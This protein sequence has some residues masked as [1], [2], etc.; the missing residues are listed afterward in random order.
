PGH[1]H[2][3][4]P[5]CGL[6]GQLEAWSDAAAYV[7]EKWERAFAKAERVKAGFAQ[8]VDDRQGIYTLAPSTHD[9]LVRWL[10]SFDLCRRP[11]LVTTDGEFHSVRRQLDRLAEE[12]VEVVRVLYRP[13]ESVAERLAVAVDG[14]TVAVI[15][16]AVFFINAHIVFELGIAMQT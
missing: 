13:A 16:S 8:L 4:W 7:D 5:D 12:R 15:A 14:R 2:Q 1:S 3:A 6:E 10:S 9:L 11:R